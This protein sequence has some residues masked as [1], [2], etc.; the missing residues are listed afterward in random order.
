MSESP[1]GTVDRDPLVL[2]DRLVEAIGTEQARIASAPDP[3]T[4]ELAP[5]AELL[6]PIRAV[7]A[8]IAQLLERVDLAW[9]VIANAS[10]GDWTQE[11]D[12]WR[13]AAV[14]WR[15]QYVASFG[16]TAGAST[17]QQKLSRLDALN[18]LSIHLMR[19]LTSSVFETADRVVDQAAELPADRTVRIELE[20]KPADVYLDE[21]GQTKAIGIP[22]RR[23]Q[24]H[25]HELVGSDFP[26]EERADWSGPRKPQGWV[27]PEDVA[28]ADPEARAAWARERDYRD[29]A[30]R[31]GRADG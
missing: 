17:M 18:E 22:P 5:G 16:L 3:R 30:A 11:S 28:P 19:D 1:K 10:D 15:D 6:E 4:V 9:G 12:Q 29:A 26:V 13:Q 7:R 24:L 23:E 2:L 25:G 20:G 21:R 14:R 31:E 27:D 8:A